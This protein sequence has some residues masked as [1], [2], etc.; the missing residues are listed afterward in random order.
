MKVNKIEK[1]FPIDSNR[2]FLS[3][4]AKS[5]ETCKHCVNN[6]TRYSLLNKH[7]KI[8]PSPVQNLQSFHNIHNIQMV[9]F[10]CLY[11]WFTK[12]KK[13]KMVQETDIIRVDEHLKVK[14]ASVPGPN[15]V[16]GVVLEINAC[17]RSD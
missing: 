4:S 8:L 1:Y 12:K 7:K 5:Q 6:I 17:R 15:G 11:G 2:T 9:L 14:E 16:Q 3:I 13:K 10:G